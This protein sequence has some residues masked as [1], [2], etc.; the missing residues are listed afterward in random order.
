LPIEGDAANSN[1][2]DAQLRAACVYRAGAIGDQV[3]ITYK[4][5]Y[6][7]RPLAFTAQRK[8]NGTP[9]SRIDDSEALTS[10]TVAQH[11]IIV[12][13]N[14]NYGLPN[15]LHARSTAYVMPLDAPPHRLWNEKLCCH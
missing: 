9:L 5:L 15:R 2:L 8:A 3:F 11:G 10:L 4:T 12:Q 6:D 7:N 13:S 1:N 14:T